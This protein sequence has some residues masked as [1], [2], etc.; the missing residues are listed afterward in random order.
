MI[1]VVVLRG[2]L[3]AGGLPF[4]VLALTGWSFSSTWL[5]SQALH[6][7]IPAL[8]PLLFLAGIAPD[9][10]LRTVLLLGALAIVLPWL[11]ARWQV[12]CAPAPTA[13]SFTVASLNC[14]VHNQRR[15][16]L[17]AALEAL[18]VDFAALQE[19]VDADEAM[20]AGRFPHRA[21]PHAGPP[22][23]WPA[24][25]PAWLGPFGLAIDHVLVRDVALGRMRSVNLPGSD[26][27]GVIAA[28]QVAP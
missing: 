12:P 7:A 4:V 11:L 14:F 21:W 25:W 27:R 9:W 16:E 8:L 5:G 15:P 17:L 6:L 13:V 1:E 19:V 28:A 26:H 24:T 3:A 18:E 2:A 22:W 23:S 10:R 20:I